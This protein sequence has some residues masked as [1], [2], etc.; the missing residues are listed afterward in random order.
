MNILLV[1]FEFPPVG[2]G[3]ANATWYLVRELVKNG[4]QVD[5]LTSR[6]KGLKKREQINGATI[7][8][9]P[10]FRQRLDYCTVKE[11]ASFAIAAIPY[12][13]MLA[14]RKRYD[15]T[16]VFFG[17]PCGHIG[18]L[19][20]RV[21]GIPYLISLRGGDV[22]GFKPHGYE[23]HYTRVKPLVKYLWDDCDALVAVS[24]G[25]RD[26]TLNIH[27]DLNKQIT[28]IPN[29]VD[30]D[31]FKPVSS[32]SGNPFTILVVSR[33]IRRKGIEYLL[34]AVRLLRERSTQPVQLLIAGDGLF[35]EGLK[36]RVKENNLENIVTFLGSI[37]HEKLPAIYQQADLFCLPSLAEGMANVILEAL[38]SGLPIIATKTSGSL[39]LVHPEVNGLLVQKADPADLMEKILILLNDPLKR[40]DFG[41]KSREMAKQFSWPMV[42]GMYEKIYKQIV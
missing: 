29:G 32:P 39:E 5:V 22:P 19:L 9:I 7:Y 41:Q 27:Q 21:F 34:D 13:L 16:H 20:K 8:R 10:V 3:G 42:T 18:W 23:K 12:A 24:Q 1:N 4:H 2:G 33:L 15:V 35:R 37:P 31:E 30:L 14:A 25:L 36:R 6:F 11:M 38:A 17:I 26:Q 40:R 28:V